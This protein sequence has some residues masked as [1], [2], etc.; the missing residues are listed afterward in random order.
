MTQEGAVVAHT[1][2]NK[3]GWAYVRIVHDGRNDRMRWLQGTHRQVAYC[4][5]EIGVG[6]RHER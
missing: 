6:S 4:L 5:N 1:S 3:T 2:H